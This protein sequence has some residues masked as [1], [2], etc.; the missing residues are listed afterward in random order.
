MTQPAPDA[1]LTA[2]QANRILKLLQC[3]HQPMVA[4]RS[5]LHDFI[6]HVIGHFEVEQA[7]VKAAQRKPYRK[8]AR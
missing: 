1:W 4:G 5:T 2:S 3:D 6:D 7:K 8:K